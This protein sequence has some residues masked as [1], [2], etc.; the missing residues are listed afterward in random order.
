M[1]GV[2]AVARLGAAGQLDPVIAAAC[3]SFGLVYVH[4]F[5]DGNGRLHRFLIH[6]ILRQ[7]KFTPD[8]VALPISARMIKNVAHYPEQLRSYSRP[9]T[10]PLGYRRR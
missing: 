5:F 2:A 4:P 8:G 9:R 1:R 7:A 3:A 6:H 10:A